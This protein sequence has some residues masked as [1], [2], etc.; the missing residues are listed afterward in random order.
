MKSYTKK[1]RN[2]VPDEFYEY[3]NS[4]LSSSYSDDEKQIIRLVFTLGYLGT[5]RQYFLLA[6]TPLETVYNYTRK[7]MLDICD[8]FVKESLKE[9]TELFKLTGILRK[10]IQQNIPLN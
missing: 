4:H 9:E 8:K 7:D 2:S 5:T 3:L 10:K 6:D 1:I